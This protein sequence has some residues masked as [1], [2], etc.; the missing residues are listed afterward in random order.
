MESAFLISLFKP[1]FGQCFS[2]GHTIITACS[3]HREL[4]LLY[5]ANRPLHW[6]SWNSWNHFFLWGRKYLF[7]FL[8]MRVCVYI[9]I[10][11]I[12]DF[13][14]QCFYS[15][16]PAFIGPSRIPSDKTDLWQGPC[17]HH[18]ALIHQ[19]FPSSRTSAVQTRNDF[20]FWTRRWCVDG[21]KNT[22]K[23]LFRWEPV[24]Q[25]KMPL[26][27]LW[28]HE[29]MGSNFKNIYYLTFHADN[30]IKNI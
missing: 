22:K 14:A 12:C 28:I 8:F 23:L 13:D 3:P 17:P 15:P 27:I 18:I 24:S 7:V 2:G 6:S 25:E 1:H 19:S 4:L 11:I 16:F 5:I 20:P 9:Y 29:G 21:E 10:N 26:I 30:L